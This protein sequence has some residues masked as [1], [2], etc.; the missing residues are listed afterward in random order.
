MESLFGNKVI[1]IYSASENEKRLDYIARHLFNAILGV[2]FSIVRDK[3]AFLRQTGACINYSDKNLNQGLW[4]VPQGLLFETGVRRI[5]EL[6]ESEWKNYFCFFRQKQGSIPFDIFAASFY[7][8]T[9]YEEYFPERLDEHGRFAIQESLLFRK[10]FLEIPLVDR[11]TYLLKDELKKKYPDTVFKERKYRFVNTFDIDH[12]YLYR[13]KG[14]L[15]NLGNTLKDLLKGD[16]N[17]ANARFAVLFFGKPDPY[18]HVIQWIDT[19]CEKVGTPYYL[20]VLMRDKGRYGRKT[21]Y[22]LTDYYA[23]LKNRRSAIVGLH[24][25]YE[26][27]GNSGLLIAEKKQLEKVLGKGAVAISRQ[28]FLRMQVPETFRDLVAAGIKEDFTTTFAHAPGFRSGTAIPY[29]FY[30]IENDITGDLLLRPTVMMDS[31]LIVHQRLRPEE[32]LEK[33]KRLVDEC[34]ESGGDYLSLWHNSNLIG[35]AQDN[36]WINV[37]IESFHY[38]VSLENGNCMPEKN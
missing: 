8:L 13:K 38:A 30:D 34:K 37:F 18:M 31:T 27:Y 7:L 33:I 25:S 26:T 14:I 32:A 1:T 20:F 11:W 10:G 28:H 35:N 9:L 6:K 29:Y 36:P 21:L 5:P 2:D 16:L 17:N 22:P 19:I 4:I 23:Y 3:D 12:P 15:K 24:P